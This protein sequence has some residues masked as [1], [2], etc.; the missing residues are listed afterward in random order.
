ME[1]FMEKNSG[2]KMDLDRDHRKK[3]YLQDPELRIIDELLNDKIINSIVAPESYTPS[4][5]IVFPCQ[6]LRSE[7]LKSLTYP[8]W[9]YRKFCKKVVND[10][11]KKE[12][13][14]FMG[15][16]LNRKVVISHGQMSQFRIQISS[17]G[18]FIGLRYI[19]F[20]QR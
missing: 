4:K 20:S 1:E 14:V 17:D 7:I 10:L 9:S 3:K 11:R 8:E 15:L 19:S 6:Y 18:E 2:K 13:R 12:Q 16:P 5:R